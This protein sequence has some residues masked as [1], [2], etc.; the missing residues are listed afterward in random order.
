MV[1]D[2]SLPNNRVER[3][4]VPPLRQILIDVAHRHGLRVETLVSPRR[5][6]RALAARWEFYYLACRDTDF[7]TTKIATITDRDH[8]SVIHGV[9]EYCAFYG[10][11]LPRSNWKRRR[12]GD[13][14]RRLPFPSNSVDNSYKSVFGLASVNP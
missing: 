7:P 2:Q 1:L 8:T 14:G 13:K 3:K 12:H 11:P 6:H 4:W 10:F 9:H 5:D